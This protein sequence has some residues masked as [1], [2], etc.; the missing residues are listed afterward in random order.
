MRLLVVDGAKQ[1][2]TKN[3]GRI[4]DKQD[5]IDDDR[6]GEMEAEYLFI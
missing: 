1:H 4:R 5:N 2:G 6:A 3:P